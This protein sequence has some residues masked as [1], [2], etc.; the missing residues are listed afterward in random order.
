M[1]TF[2]DYFSDT[3]QTYSSYRPGYPEQLFEAVAAHSIRRDLLWDCATGNGQAAIGLAK[4]FRQVI[5]TDASGTQIENAFA[6]PNVEYRVAAAEKS[7]L[8][9]RSID[10]VTVA[11]ALHWFDLERF[12]T[13]VHRVLKPGGLF[14]AWS[15][16]HSSVDD[17]VDMVLN[18]LNSQVLSNYWAPEVRFV[19]EEYQSLQFP[20]HEITLAPI[21]MRVEWNLHQYLGYLQTWSAVRECLRRE[22]SGALEPYFEALASAWGEA[23]SERAVATKLFVRM[24]TT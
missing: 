17:N 14:A 21:W 13:E 19:Q 20:F 7:E 11:Q 22:G 6:A 10:A 8:K 3:A 5:A 9:D 2:K 1:E 4:Y 12:Y 18:S 16:G 15:Y 24:G 23:K